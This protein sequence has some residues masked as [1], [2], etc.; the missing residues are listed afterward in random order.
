MELNQKL[1]KAFPEDAR[2]GEFTWGK[3]TYVRTWGLE[4]LLRLWV[5]GEK[6]NTVS[7][8]SKLAVP[9]KKIAL[10]LH[11]KPTTKRYRECKYSSSQLHLLQAV[12]T[13]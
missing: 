2:Y 1:T 10:Q 9:V 6:I 5:S 13:A 11:Y 4:I 12:V 8:C 3:N 7:N